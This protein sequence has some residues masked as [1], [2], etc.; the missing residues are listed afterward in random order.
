MWKNI[1]HLACALLLALCY[2]GS[3]T[4]WAEDYFGGEEC[5]M[6]QVA[7]TRRRHRQLL[8][9]EGEYYQPCTHTEDHDSLIDLSSNHSD[10]TGIESSLPI[11]AGTADLRGM[12]QQIVVAAVYGAAMQPAGFH[13]TEGTGKV[14][15][16][17]IGP[18]VAEKTK[19]SC[20]FPI[21]L[22]WFPAEFCSDHTA[23]LPVSEVSHQLASFEDFSQFLAH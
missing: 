18:E 19:K 20:G 16:I 15:R 21:P 6:I 2:I 8:G 4:R 7:N 3:I 13:D 14:F 9:F 17:G 22:R 23:M 12:T 1:N 5:E 10:A 11:C